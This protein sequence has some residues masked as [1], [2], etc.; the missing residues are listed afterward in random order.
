[1]DEIGTRMHYSFG[2]HDTISRLVVNEARLMVD[3]RVIPLHREVTHPGALVV[4]LRV[5][6]F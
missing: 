1:M 2:R 3:V 6:K 4:M 5:V